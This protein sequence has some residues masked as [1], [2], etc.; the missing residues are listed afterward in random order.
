[1][2]TSVSPSFKSREIP[3][4][5]FSHFLSTHT[6]FRCGLKGHRNI[7]SPCTKMPPQ[8]E[9]S[10]QHVRLATNPIWLST[11]NER[12]L[13]LFLQHCRNYPHS[14]LC[15]MKFF[16]AESHFTHPDS[17]VSPSCCYAP[18]SRAVLRF[19]TVHGCLSQTTL[20]FF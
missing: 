14:C 15:M 4:E 6:V 3:V 8:R 17:Q 9:H 7:M 12:D 2:K 10:L 19:P 20:R 16:A 13:A 18:L 1:M 5:R 11:C